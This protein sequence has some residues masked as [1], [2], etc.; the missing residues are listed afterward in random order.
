MTATPIRAVPPFLYLPVRESSAGVPVA[1]LR[2]LAD[3]R[4]TILAYTALDR[5][6]DGC[7]TAQPWVAIRTEELSEIRARQ[8]FDLV[9]MDVDVPDE[10]RPAGRVL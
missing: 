1:E 6:L 7:G 10:F 3:G 5:L 9:S 4:V 8:P 2:A